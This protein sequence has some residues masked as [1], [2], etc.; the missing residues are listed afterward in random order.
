MSAKL[1][2][3]NGQ[4]VCWKDVV[5]GGPDGGGVDSA[6]SAVKG[7]SASKLYASF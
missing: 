3:L 7:G 1:P 2:V 4:G 6:T 5:R